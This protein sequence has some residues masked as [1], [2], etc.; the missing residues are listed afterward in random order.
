MDKKGKAKTEK[1]EEKTKEK[2]E[3]IRKKL[4]ILKD[5]Q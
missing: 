2:Q 1:I 4:Y 3:F 5:V